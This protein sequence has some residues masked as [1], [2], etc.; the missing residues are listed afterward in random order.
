MSAYTPQLGADTDLWTTNNIGEVV[1]GAVS[2]LT[3]SAI[4][5][6]LEHAF[7]RPNVILGL[8][9]WDEARHIRFFKL[10]Q[11]HAYLN[12]TELRRVSARI[13]G[14]SAE[15]ID[16]MFLGNSEAG[17]M[18]AE[19]GRL[20]WREALRLPAILWHLVRF[21]RSTPGEAAEYAVQARRY[22]AEQEAANRTAWTDEQLLSAVDEFMA[23]FT[24]GLEVHIAASFFAMQFLDALNR[25]VT[26]VVLGGDVGGLAGRMV[27]AQGGIESAAPGVALW[28]IS[29]HIVGSPALREL[30]AGP[31]PGLTGCPAPDL[32]ARLQE[33]PEGRALW[34]QHIQPFLAE[35]GYRSIQEAELMMPNWAEDPSY[36]LSVLANYCQAGPEA[37]PARREAERR[38]DRDAAIQQVE[39]RLGRLSPQRP[40]FRYLLG[41]TQLFSL[42]RENLKS[43]VIKTGA[44][45]RG[46]ARELGRRLHEQGLLESDDVYFLR[47]DELKALLRGQAAAAE[48]GE[49]ARS[50]RAQYRQDQQHTPPEIICGEVPVMSAMAGDASAPADNVLHGLP[51]SPG[52]A[53]GRARVI[54]DPRACPALAPGD[55]LVAPLTDPGWT[56]L[57]LTAG[58]LVV[59]LG[60]LLSHGSIVA[61]EYGI[62]AVVNTKHAMQ[63]IRDGQM[64]TVDGNRG[65]VT[66]HDDET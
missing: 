66:L 41:Q 10:H 40:V 24:R 1:P 37:D 32:P 52:R 28:D 12:L 30:F 50:R 60:S 56:P 38:A 48:L 15:T 5:E 59:D 51:C 14:G 4:H 36:V 47:V 26:G 11:G 53:T 2:P 42:L 35:Y 46:A 18:P 25:L 17:S 54:A 43:D 13:P 39:S 64:V 20:G 65:T 63:A 31:G 6:P 21:I 19:G 33:S 57:F 16:R 61:R 27:A 22:R 8:M 44:G 7:V 9:T 45:G 49:L 29:R 3:W 34:T 62:P 23:I 55:I 58:G